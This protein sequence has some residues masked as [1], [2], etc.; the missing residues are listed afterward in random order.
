MKRRKADAELIERFNKQFPVGFKFEW[1]PISID[2]EPYKT[3]TVRSA[4]FDSYG[5]AVAF[6]KEIS[7]YVSI[8]P[9]FVKY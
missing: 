1:R 2:T 6:V 4:A 9:L 3:L 5:Q 8:E 7:G